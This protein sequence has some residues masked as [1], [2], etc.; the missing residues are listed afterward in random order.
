MNLFNYVITTVYG[1]QI[2]QISKIK[3]NGYII[4]DLK[5][6][7]Y[8]LWEEKYLKKISKEENPEYFL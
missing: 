8:G 3:E 5:G 6:F 4:Q 2:F 7:T 1:D